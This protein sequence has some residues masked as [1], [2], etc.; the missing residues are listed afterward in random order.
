M[1]IYAKIKHGQTVLQNV[2]EVFSLK[3]IDFYF[4]FKTFIIF[5][6]QRF[7]FWVRK[8][9]PINANESL[10]GLTDS[11]GK[12]IFNKKTDKQARGYSG[13]WHAMV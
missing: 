10:R 7:N 11:F 13:I 9:N 1:H 12:I 3:V 8:K 4:L 5:Q 2:T 6:N